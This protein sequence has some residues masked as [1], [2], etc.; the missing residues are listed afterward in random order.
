[1]EE[2]SAGRWGQNIMSLLPF[3]FYFLGVRLTVGISGRA[4]GVSGGP[5]SLWEGFLVSS[6]HRQK[7]SG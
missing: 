5:L 3:W 2:D 7:S 6:R 1:M 4:I